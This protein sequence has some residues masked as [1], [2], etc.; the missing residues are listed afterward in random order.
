[1]SDQ[2]QR[3]IRLEIGLPSGGFPKTLYYNRFRVDR[4][5]GF[6]LAQFGL[7]VASDLVDHYSCVFCGDTL[8]QNQ[9]TLIEYLNRLGRPAETKPVSW[10]GITV[11][12][13]TDV[14]DVIT[15][16]YRGDVAETA[17]YVFSL[18]AATRSRK[19]AAAETSLAAQPLVLLRSSA[20]LQKQFIVSLYEE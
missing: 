16:A 5:N 4:D 13:Q 6:S 9:Q 11:S 14:A 3:E 12:R 7:F 19:G 1:M 2:Q 8:K 10:K 17:L 15:M 20:E 18:S